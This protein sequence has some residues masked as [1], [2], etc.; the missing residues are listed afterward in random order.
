MWG[1]LCIVRLGYSKFST[2]TELAAKL[3]E[4]AARGQI[5]EV[6]DKYISGTGKYSY[7]VKD[8][9]EVSVVHGDIYVDE[10]AIKQEEIK[11]L[12]TR[13]AELENANE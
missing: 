3:L 6:D 7:I 9:P 10:D 12:K 5:K 8:T 4:A 1:K 2:T 11:R 13:L